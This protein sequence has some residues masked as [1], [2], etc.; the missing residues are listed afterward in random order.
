MRAKIFLF[1]AVV[2]VVAITV[3]L[4]AFP[5][6]PVQDLNRNWKGKSL[7]ELTREFPGGAIYDQVY[8]ATNIAG[9]LRVP[10]SKTY[11]IDDPKSAG[12]LIHELWW[13]R[14]DLNYTFFLHQ[15]D[16]QWV[17]L[18]AVKWRKDVVF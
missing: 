11:P 12:V 8:P 14:G 3:G 9:E 10:I 7:L 1:L 18:D 6:P 4:V 5:D 16:G 13:R 17:V 2:V 15:V